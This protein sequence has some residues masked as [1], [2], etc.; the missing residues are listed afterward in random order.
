VPPQGVALLGGEHRGNPRH[1]LPQRLGGG[2]GHVHVVVREGDQGVDLV[3]IGRLPPARLG[4]LVVGV[5]QRVEQAVVLVLHPLA[6]R[7]AGE[8][9]N[10]EPQVLISLR[11]KEETRHHAAIGAG[12]RAELP[13]GRGYL[14]EQGVVD[15]GLHRGGR[16]GEA[17]EHVAREVPAVRLEDVRLEVREHGREARIGGVELFGGCVELDGHDGLPG[18]I[19]ADRPDES[20]TH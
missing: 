12:R 4:V 2:L 15:P 6:E 3:L 5:E 19:I 14:R 8:A 20:L 11:R 18:W 13:G 10:L 1:R 17:E 16:R 9:A 7:A